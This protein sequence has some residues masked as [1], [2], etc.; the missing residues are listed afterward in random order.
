MNES[1]TLVCGLNWIGDSIMA[2]PALHAF[3]AQGSTV[4]SVLV[5]PGLV[6]L[7]KMMS[8]IAKVKSL[9]PGSMGTLRTGVSLR[10][11][12][13]D[14]AYILPNSFRSALVPFLAGIPHR[15]GYAAQERRLLLTEP[16]SHA[17]EDRGL[18]QAWEYMRLLMPS[19]DEEVLP[20][21]PALTVDAA[22]R[23]AV[24]ERL[25]EGG[26]RWVGLVPGAA[27]GA[28][29]RWP[30]QHFITVGRQVVNELH[31]RVAVMGAAG[32]RELCEQV[33]VAIGSAAV[34]LAGETT[35]PMWAELLSSCDVVVANDSGGMH[36]A[37]AMGTPVVAVYGQTDPAK[38]GP[39]GA[40]T[41]LQRS[42][43][44]DRRIARDSEAARLSLA[45][46]QPNEVYEATR[47]WLASRAGIPEGG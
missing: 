18:H 2:M 7:W 23:A 1:R 46:I 5:K 35:L 3:I 19:Y 38:T 43:V 4:V 15:I 34:N 25:G 22:S 21:M 24:A 26:Q 42:N 36:L 9:P 16:R 14:T 11:D 13:F 28:A 44:R 41:V 10:S 47:E 27:R 8:G 37:S 29:K 39:L 45:S 31:C 30:Q 12:N 6:P 32:E 33:A 20:P 40:S 17:R